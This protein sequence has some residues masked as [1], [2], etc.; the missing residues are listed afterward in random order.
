MFYE[1]FERLC[2]RRGISPSKAG[3]EVGYSKSTASAWKKN[4]TIPKESDLVR[5]AELLGCSVKD[6]FM[7]EDEAAVDEFHNAHIGSFDGLTEFMDTIHVPGAKPNGTDRTMMMLSRVESD[8]IST[9]RMGDHAWR[10][11]MYQA[12][13]RWKDTEI[14]K[15]GGINALID[16]YEQ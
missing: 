16:E 4:G 5:L 8:I 6:F 13:Q 10:D 12:I 2:Q 11:G 9:F 3:I 7:T 15:R 14:H 1:N